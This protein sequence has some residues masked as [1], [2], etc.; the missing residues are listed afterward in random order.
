MMTTGFE[1]CWMKEVIAM[2]MKSERNTA[3]GIPLVS[4]A[5]YSAYSVIRKNWNVQSVSRCFYYRKFLYPNLPV[6]RC[7]MKHNADTPT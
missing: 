4:P 5:E 2:S 3:T 1:N 6:I 7:R